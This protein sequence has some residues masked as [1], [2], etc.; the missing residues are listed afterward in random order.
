MN[1]AVKIFLIVLVSLGVGF[2][3]GMEYKSYQVRSALKDVANEISNSFS[4]TNPP[5]NQLPDESEKKITYIN[6]PVGEEV[7]LATIKFKVNN[8]SE[9]QT[10][11]SGYGSPA[12]AKEGAKF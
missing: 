2:F 9:K 11:S 7:I 5:E 10:L 4:N 8:S 1:N 3:A 12:I 6:K